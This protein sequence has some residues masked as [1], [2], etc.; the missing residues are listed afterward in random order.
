VDLGLSEQEYRS[1]PWGHFAALVSRKFKVYRGHVG[2]GM[3]RPGASQDQLWAQI[4]MI[5]NA[6]TKEK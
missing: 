4:G 5:H 6:L 1:M 3:G 2:F